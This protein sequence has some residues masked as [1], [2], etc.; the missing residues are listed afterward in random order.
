VHVNNSQARKKPAA[1]GLNWARRAKL[2]P[3]CI[4]CRVDLPLFS[5]THLKSMVMSCNKCNMKKP[6]ALAALVH[7]IQ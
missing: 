2:P 6:P 5:E 1:D 4:S 3:C 7:K